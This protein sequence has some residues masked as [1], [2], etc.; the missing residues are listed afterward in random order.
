LGFVEL[1]I[2]LL[3]VQI[4]SEEYDLKFHINDLSN[5]FN[6]QRKTRRYL[7]DTKSLERLL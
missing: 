7:F 5:K 1:F 6:K 4:N 2:A 3:C